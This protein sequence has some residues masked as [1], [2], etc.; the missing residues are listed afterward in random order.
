MENSMSRIL[1][2][3]VVKKALKDIKDS[4][5]RGIRNLIDLAL[6]FS[7][8]RFQQ[9]FFSTAQSMLQ[10][11]N[12]A[13]YGLV[14]N[15]VFNTDLDR[16]HTFGMNLGY[17]GCTVGARRIRQNEEKMNCNIPWSFSIQI[18]TDRFEENRQR[19]HSFIQEGESLGIYVWMLFPM[20]HA[21]KVLSLAAAHPD[22]AFCIFCTG[23][24]LTAEF[25]DEAADL[26][27][28][29]LIIRYKEQPSDIYIALQKMGLLYSVWYPYDQKDTELII[30]GDLF[31]CTQQVSPVFTVLLP[32]PDCPEEIRRIA[33]Q[34]VKRARSNQTFRTIAW[35]FQ[36][37]NCL[38]DSIISNDTCSVYLDK[39]GNLCDWDGKINSTAHNWSGHSLAEILV[40]S[41]PKKQGDPL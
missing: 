1:I 33:Y 39:K 34:T 26:F 31:S 41:C 16:L 5:E 28:V 3:T 24:D 25:L 19:Y 22:S 6:Q 36:K 35:E 15:T 27:N 8:S 21:E 11:E 40:R 12:S 9:N 13:Y 38:I 29:M 14:R 10:N 18:D 7:G 30:N 4:P 37:D 20:E 32:E 17:N 2:E 23:S